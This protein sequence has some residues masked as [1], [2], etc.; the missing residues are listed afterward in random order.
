MGMSDAFGK[1]GGG[2]RL[3][4]VAG[5]VVGYQFSTD[6]PYEAK[7]PKAGRKA[8]K[9]NT[10]WL[11]LDILQ[12]GETESKIEPLFA[13]NADQWIISDDGLTISPNPESEKTPQLFGNGPRFLQSAFDNGFDE[14]EYAEGDDI[15]LESLIDQRFTFIQVTDV[16]GT[17]ARG[18]QVDKKD[19]TKKYDR[20][21]LEVSEVLGAAE[22]A[23]KAG[24]KGKTAAKP[25]V[26]AKGGKKAA[27]VEDDHT[28]EAAETLAAVL[29]ANDGEINKSKVGM[30]SLKMLLKNK[31]GNKDAVAAVIKSDD[32]LA[33][34]VSWSYN[35]KTGVI[36]ADA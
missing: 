25:A 26:A 35:K 15:N 3:N 31:S 19:P 34:E 2:G 14:P 21:T 18:Q 23:P 11:N 33:T 10:L 16:E 8:S 20:K 36:S 4:N 27:P 17:K 9:F 13:G 5:T 28:V 7:N 6:F 1:G 12:D 29:A 24:A 22:P 32:F 30:A